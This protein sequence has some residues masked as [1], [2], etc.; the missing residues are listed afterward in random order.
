M[1]AFARLLSGGK[2][3][4]AAELSTDRD[5]QRLQLQ[6][7]ERALV[8]ARLARP[9]DLSET[10]YQCLRYAM[11]LARIHRFTP[12][13]SK[14]DVRINLG[15]NA[16][17]AD[18]LLAHL[19]A[20]LRSAASDSERL[21]TCVQAMPR[22]RELTARAREALLAS[23]PDDFD[24][25]A[26][27]REAGHRA[28]VSVAGGG[29]GA[30]YVYLGAYA[31]LM[32]ADLTPDY[33]V[34]N[35]IGAVMGLFRAARRRIEVDEYLAFAKS[36]SRA[37]VF[38]AGRRRA[39]L[40]LPGLLQ[41]H[42]KV[43]HSR[44]V[45]G[46]HR[47]PLRLDEMEIPLDLIVAGVRRRSLERMPDDVREPESGASRLLPFSMKLASRLW[48]L[49][50]FF[51]PTLV[52]PL[53]FG[54]DQDTRSLHAVDVVGFSAAVPTILQYELRGRAGTS[55]EIFAELMNRHDLSALVDG[56]VADNVPA[57]AAWEGVESGRIGT[58]NAYYL[59]FDCFQPKWEPKH[60]WLWPISQAVQMQ[61]RSNRVY[62]DSMVRFSPT[63]SP[64][65]LVPAAASL[66]QAFQ[67]GW[68]QMDARLPEVTAM[69]QP[70]TWEA[71]GRPAMAAEAAS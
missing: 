29:G 4:S 23:H 59:A 48:R 21:A 62:A 10:D 33:M 35:S 37:D 19:Y 52:K 58:R 30:G 27:D 24:A 41:L 12:R 1:R 64:I 40:C 8:R 46:D 25:A 61:M 44:F 5:S 20:P 54:R 17:L 70:A 56:G 31:R 39:D 55:R 14:R 34:G 16:T 3:L 22:V 32:A 6:R 66:D 45:T 57:R 50:S 11:G 7:M 65:N 60:L 38:T 47:R 18:W 49:A 9:Q 2:T 71:A 43:L 53:V 42:L 51:S 13:G 69:L 67:W 28:F 63:L 26:L 15:A 36:L 68:D